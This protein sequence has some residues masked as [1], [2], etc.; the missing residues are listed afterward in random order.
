M[1][2]PKEKSLWKW[3]KNA[4]KAYYGALHMGRI[5]NN[6]GSG[7]PDVEGHLNYHGQ[8]WIELKVCKRPMRISTP[9]RPK[10]REAQVEWIKRR[11]RI[12]GNVWLLIQIGKERYLVHGKHVEAI[13]KGV[14]FPHL[15]HI[16]FRADSPQDIFEHIFD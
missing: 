13:H 11:S 10:I 4:K 1:S 16:G 8:F 2:T 9:V 12:G 5:E 3:L 7:M 14:G 15:R 6:V